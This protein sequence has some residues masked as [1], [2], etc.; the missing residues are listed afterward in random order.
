MYTIVILNILQF[1]HICDEMQQ[2]LLNNEVRVI[3]C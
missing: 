1:V 2:E 3:V